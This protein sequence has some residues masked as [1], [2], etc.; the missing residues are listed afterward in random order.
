MQELELSV[1]LDDPVLTEVLPPATGAAQHLVW[2]AQ[3]DQQQ[4]LQKEFIEAKNLHFS[5]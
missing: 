1:L 2:R 3:V 5:K 4:R